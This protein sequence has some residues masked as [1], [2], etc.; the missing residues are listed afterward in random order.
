[1]SI[2]FYKTLQILPNYIQFLFQDI[3]LVCGHELVHLAT[4]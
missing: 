2:S 4:F 3:S 1:M